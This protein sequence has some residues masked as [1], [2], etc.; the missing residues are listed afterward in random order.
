MKK[1]RCLFVKKMLQERVKRCAVNCINM[2]CLTFR[3]EKYGDSCA[4]PCILRINMHITY[5]FSYRK[6]NG[7]VMQLGISKNFKKKKGECINHE[8]AD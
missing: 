5:N 8:K 3:G 7:L 2:R 4:E 6:Y 1:E